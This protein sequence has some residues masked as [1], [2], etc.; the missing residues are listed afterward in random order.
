MFISNNELRL[1]YSLLDA[2][3]ENNLG[4]NWNL[5]IHCKEGTTYEALRPLV[6]INFRMSVEIV[7]GVLGKVEYEGLIESADVALIPYTDTSHIGAGSGKAM[8]ALGLG[9]PIIALE[10]SHACEKGCKVKGCFPFKDE[11]PFSI[12]QAL[13]S[14]SASGFMEQESQYFRKVELQQRV[15]M[16]MGVESSL[17]KLFS[18]FSTQSSSVPSSGPYMILVVYWFAVSR[19]QMLLSWKKRRQNIIS[20]F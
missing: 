14:Y 1:T 17:G 11:N 7:T 4:E 2:I 15:E 19:I 5:V 12:I 8:D 20:V 18:N 9:I 10:G 3:E 16:E 13:K 6:S